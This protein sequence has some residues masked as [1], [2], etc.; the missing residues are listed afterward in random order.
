MGPPRRKV[1]ATA[2]A[3]LTPPPTL[4]AAQVI[5]RVI[6]AEGNNLYAVET[7][8][9]HN[10]LVELAPQF[11]STIWLKRGGFVLVDTTTSGDRA[12][13]IDGEITNVVSDEK[14]WRKEPYWPKEFG[15]K[16]T[17]TL[18]DDEEDRAGKM[19]HDSSKGS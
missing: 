4:T 15:K 14:A 16:S 19:P 5:A 2:E 11:R 6:K 3:T 10:L 9:L 13:K 17:H 8:A 1:R 12:N 7:A 18:S